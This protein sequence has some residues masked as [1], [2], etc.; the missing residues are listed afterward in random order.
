MNKSALIG[1]TGF[2]GSSLKRHFDLKLNSKSSIEEIKEINVDELY[3][4]APSGVKWK[5]NR[6]PSEDRLSCKKL[7]S[8]ITDKFKNLKRIILISSNDTL[9]PTCPYGE[10]RKEFNDSLEKYCNEN[11]IELFIFYLGMTFGKN[12]RKGM[13]FDFF[14]RKF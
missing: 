6:Q 4:C 7:Y 8:L 13:V 11:Q 2:I 10:N 9:E 5:A 3:V 1:Y 12:A 14:E